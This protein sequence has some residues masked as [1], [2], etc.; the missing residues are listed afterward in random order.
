MKD[1]RP[2][3]IVNCAM[4][5]DGKIAGMERQQVKISDPMDFAR[6]HELRNECGAIIVGVGTVVADD[7]SLLV[8][9]KY[10]PEPRHP[11]RVVIDPQARVPDGSLVLDKTAEALI[12]LASETKREF[13]NAE[14]IICEKH[15]KID[16]EKLMVRLW[17]MGIRKVLVEGGG[18]TI[19]HFF[20]RGLVDRLSIFVGSLI[21]GGNNSPTPV[22]GMGFEIGEHVELRL[23]KVEQ[24]ECGVILE[25]T[26][27][28]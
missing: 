11:I 21:I 6:V 7:P 5:A 13:K 16:L 19:Y 25:Y 8:K 22:D 14:K 2:V 18:E 1:K 17:D 4:S 24:T 28:S 12:V 3:V 23:D 15:G 20:E 27:V 9:G 10:V 26:V